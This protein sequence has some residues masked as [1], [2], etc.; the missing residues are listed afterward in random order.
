M[1]HRIKKILLSLSACAIVGTANAQHSNDWQQYFDELAAM[2]DID[3]NTDWEQDYELYT[4]LAKSPINL[5]TATREQIEELPFLTSQQSEDLVEYLE[6]Y[7][8]VRSK[9]ELMMVKSLE[10]PQR[11]LLEIFTYIGEPTTRKRSFAESIRN[12][13]HELSL[14]ARIPTYEREGDRD[15]AYGGYPYRHTVRYRFD[16]ENRLTLG[17]TAAQDAGEPFFANK[18]SLGYDHYALYALATD[19]GPVER[20]AIG[21]FRLST[22]MGLVVNNNLSFG[23]LATLQ[24]LGRR[25]QTLRVGSSRTEGRH[26]QGAAAT[27]RMNKALKLTAFLS[28]RPYDGTVASGDTISNIN[29]T[30]YH[31][32]KSEL[33]RKGNTHATAAGANIAFRWK[34]FRAGATAIYTHLDRYL[35]PSPSLTYRRYYPQGTDFLNAS[36]D[37]SYAS[38][39]ITVNGETAIGD[40]GAIATIN[41]L[42]IGL[43]KRVNLLALQRFYSYRY[44]SPYAQSFSDG[45]RVQNESGIYIGATWQPTYGSR[46]TAYADIA[47]FPWARYQTSK[48]SHSID[49]FCSALTQLKQWQLSARYRARLRQTDNDG[50]TALTANN[51][52]RARVAATYDDGKMLKNSTQA[53]VAIATNEGTSTGW[54][55]S[56]QATL[57]HGIVAATAHFAYFHTDDYASRIYCYER[58]LLYDFSFPM[59]S[60][61][62]IR[63]AFLAT[64]R[65]SGSLRLTA[66]VGV[67][68]YFD[69]ATIGTGH[70]KIDA[71]S[72]ADIDFQL[73]WRF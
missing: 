36:I 45:G 18:N 4:E 64:A 2:E 49:I 6:R 54:M 1:N 58:G 68:D 35:Q 13:R 48:S 32:T 43:P 9:N 73:I 3:V 37:Y 11:K 25:Q 69:R 63:Y 40:N 67:T 29:T 31:R 22:G 33:D 30:G 14:S 42:S 51:S 19:I 71:S 27:V 24:S 44:S 38:R 8:P 55:V 50:G 57:R 66:K 7:G 61:E 15:G 70:Q 21:T 65:L 10:L 5:N 23:K 20:L 72:Q 16:A 26:F 56:N 52:H 60:G 17:L 47:Y 53:D 39:K 46:L 41:C 59:F 34:R 12:G 28:W 62:G